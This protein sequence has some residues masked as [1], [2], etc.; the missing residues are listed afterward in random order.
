M[1]QIEGF[2]NHYILPDG[3][4]YRKS[5]NYFMVQKK[6]N[7][8]YFFVE[9]NHKKI[10]K[11]L[12]IHRLLAK[13]YIGNPSNFPVVHHKDGNK[14]NNS[15]SNLEWT[16]QSL[17]IKHAFDTGLMKRTNNRLGINHTGKTKLK[18]IQNN[19]HR[20]DIIHLLTGVFYFSINDAAKYN[21]IPRTTLIRNLR[22]GVYKNL[23]LC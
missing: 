14:E 7:A 4:V 22:R 21:Q 18:I 6:T 11:K 19:P 23:L 3:R 9:L 15:V 2:P 17:N 1:K 13:Y 12:T 16:T 5:N 20:K 10:N 8:G